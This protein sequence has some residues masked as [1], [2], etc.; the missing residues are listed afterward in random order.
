MSIASLLVGIGG[1]GVWSIGM[2]LL[3][4]HV[5]TKVDNL[6]EKVDELTER[7]ICHIENGQSK[8]Q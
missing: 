3:L 7:L 5:S 4:C 8:N 1:F 6:T 2:A